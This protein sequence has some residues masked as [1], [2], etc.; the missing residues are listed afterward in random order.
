[1][2]R[3]G[4]ALARAFRP[5]VRKAGGEGGYWL[6]LGGGFVP[7]D[8]PLNF[9]QMGY[10]PLPATRSAVV[11]A[12]ISAYAQTFAMC[13]GS[14]WRRKPDGGRERV[15]NSALA[16]ILK[17]PNSY[18]SISDFL[19]N[20]GGQLYEHGNAY[21]LAVRNNRFE[22]QEL[23]LMRSTLSHPRI[24]VDGSVFYSLA[25]NEIVERTFGFGALSAVPARDVL[26]VRLET[27]QHP[28]I[29]EPPLF[30][31]MLDV[32]TSDMTVRQ[33]LNFLS[34]RGNPSGVIET[35]M[36]LDRDQI[37]EARQIWDEQTRGSGAG[38]TPILTN[39]LKWQ[40]VTTNSRDA[41]L[42]EMLQIS[43]QRIA[44]A[45]RVPLPLLSVAQMRQPLGS[46][47]SLM[48]F[49]V[50]AGLGFALN[51]IEEAF[52]RFF[53]LAG[54]P[55]EYL[56]L[57]TEA[58]LR[59]LRKDRVDTLVKGVQGGLYS[60]NEAR[61]FEDLPK[62]ENGDEPRVQQQ[63]VPL[64]FG[65]QAPEPPPQDNPPPSGGGQLTDAG[66]VGNRSDIAASILAAA[67]RRTAA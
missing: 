47:E 57:D 17:T 28:L 22:V 59:S 49:W 52:G 62:V 2:T 34:N 36:A 20:L 64:S 48:Q 33:V 32:A 14:H 41:Q 9:W 38:G 16:R 42:A 19:L 66:Y 67:A 13:P 56:E 30:S 39:G 46:T 40:Q 7:G 29:G 21:M 50:A 25:G 23:H 27:K 60:P 35:D 61:A 51:H 11:Y 65:A 6:P 37:K 53:G 1:M 44:T 31:A 63:V 12:C 55:D 4:K 8:W 15:A 54:W 24:G 3:A 26:H 5:P 58:L 43:D 45:F 10:N 18:Q